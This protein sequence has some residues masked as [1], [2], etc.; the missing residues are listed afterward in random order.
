VER[1]I[2]SPECFV[3]HDAHVTDSV[4]FPGVRVSPGARLHRAIVDKGVVIPP[5]HRIGFDHESDRQRFKVS[6]Q[7][8]VVI[9]KHRDLT[10]S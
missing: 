6:D 9:E 7:G 3:D 8:I 2:I 5:G 10:T 4:L 1:S